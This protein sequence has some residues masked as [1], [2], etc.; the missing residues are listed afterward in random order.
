MV[1]NIHKFQWADLVIVA[2][3]MGTASSV[4]SMPSF[5]GQIGFMVSLK[6][7]LE[8]MNITLLRLTP[9]WVR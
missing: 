2:Y 7:L 4:S 8:F 6:D 3:R 5:V 9:I 1:V